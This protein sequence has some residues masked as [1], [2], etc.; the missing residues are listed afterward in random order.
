MHASNAPAIALYEAYGFQ[1]EAVRKNYWRMRT[2]EDALIYWKRS[3]KA[4]TDE[5]EMSILFNR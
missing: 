5:M 2:D 4:L 3:G 1:K